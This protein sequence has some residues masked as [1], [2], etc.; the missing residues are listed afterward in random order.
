MSGTISI[1][2][3]LADK[4]N[5]GKKEDT[6]KKPTAPFTEEAFLAQWKIYKDKLLADGQIMFASAFENAPEI[7]GTLIKVIVE[8]KAIVDEFTAQKP[9]ILDFFRATLNNY[10]IDFEL[11]I[12]KDKANKKAFTPEEKFEKM[13]EKNPVLKLLRD[14]LDLEVGY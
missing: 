5:S 13:S 1:K 11:T 7:E 4:E 2:E 6:S 9:D 3:Q 14:R 8:N 10:N 12:N